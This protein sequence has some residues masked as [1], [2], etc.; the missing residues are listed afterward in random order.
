MSSNSS[1]TSGFS[2]LK[3]GCSGAKRWRYHSPSGTRVHA[4]PPK[5]ESQSVGASLPS[6]PR[7]GRKTYRARSGLPGPA[8]SAAWNQTCWSEEW[9]GT[10]STITR[11]PWSWAS[12]ISRSASSS[13]PKSG[14]MSR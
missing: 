5:V 9:L 4:G 8:A 11:M 14:S 1:T 10:M 3:S 2:Q 6:S 12:A 7:P 13:V